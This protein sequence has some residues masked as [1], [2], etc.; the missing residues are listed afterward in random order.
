MSYR[1]FNDCLIIHILAAHASQILSFSYSVTFMSI[2]RH[3]K[4]IALIQSNYKKNETDI[5]KPVPMGLTLNDHQYT[6]KTCC[7]EGCAAYESDP[8]L[9]NRAAKNTKY[10]LIVWEWPTFPLWPSVWGCHRAS[11]M[12]SS[13]QFVWSNSTSPR[14]E[15]CSW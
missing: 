14:R 10:H 5:P 15:Y 9:S 2:F 11:P 1:I 8:V 13:C 4:L 3:L 6:Q 7:W 12:Y